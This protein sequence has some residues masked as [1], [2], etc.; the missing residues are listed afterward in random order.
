MVYQQSNWVRALTVRDNVAIPL[1]LL[2]LQRSEAVR[3]AD[4][5]LEQVGLRQLADHRPTELSGGQQQRVAVAR[6]LIHN[7]SILIADEPTGNLDFESGTALMQLLKDLHTQQHKTIIMVTHDLEY[8]RYADRA[9]KLFD[10]KVEQIVENVEEA[11]FNK[12]LST[13]LKRGAVTSDPQATPETKPP[14]RSGPPT[15]QRR[16]TKPTV[17][18][19]SI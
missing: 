4:Q 2:G 14:A 12:Q 11:A 5:A 7:P 1:L 15:L 8:V 18:V 16:T 10:G 3:R 19:V 13:Q 17:S 9:V 6:A